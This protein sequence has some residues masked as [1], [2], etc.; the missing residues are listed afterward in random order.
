MIL[1]DEPRWVLTT[2][3]HNRKGGYLYRYTDTGRLGISCIAR[4]ENGRVEKRSYTYAW[5]PE[6]EFATYSA[7]RDAVSQLT[8]AQVAVE[9]AKYPLTRSVE[10]EQC[11]NKCRLCQQPGAVAVHL[12]ESP[13]PMDDW[14]HSLCEL[15]RPL[16]DRPRALLLALRTEV[17]LRRARREA[18]ENARRLSQG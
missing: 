13:D 10:P 14:P 16:V 3:G 2:H 7:L 12:A 17:D 8:E 15:H 6:Q 1:P 18:A 5:L 11:G 9:K 4:S